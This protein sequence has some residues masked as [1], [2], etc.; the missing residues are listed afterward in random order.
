LLKQQIFTTTTKTA[1]IANKHSS[2][3]TILM[4]ILIIL[5]GLITSIVMILF[6]KKFRIYLKLYTNYKQQRKRHEQEH[7]SSL[8]TTRL[9]LNEDLFKH[10]EGSDSGNGAIIEDDINKNLLNNQINITNDF[11]IKFQ[12]IDLTS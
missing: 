5:A 11:K 1:I 12:S 6:I 9:L 7:L 4:I 10:N 3:L 8:K 2:I